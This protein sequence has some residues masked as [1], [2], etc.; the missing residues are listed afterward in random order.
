MADMRVISADSHMTEPGDLWVE[1]LDR[2]FRDNAP[3]VIKK[4][5]SPGSS[6]GA[7]Y[8]FVGPGFHPLTVA[9][10]FAAGRSGDELRE[11][12]RHGY[13]AARPSGWDPVERLKD[14]DLDGVSAE[15][16]YASLGIALLSMTDAD[17][18]QAC[19]RVYNDW[20][21]EFCSHA[22]NRLAGIG[23]FSLNSLP[24][25]SAI[26]HCAK[27]GLRGML[28]LASNTIDIP[29]SDERFDPLWRLASETGMPISLHKPLVSAM[30]TTPFMPSPADLQIHCIHVVEQCMTRL[31]YGGVFERFPRL[32]V[33]TIEA[34][35]GWVGEWLERFDYRYKY[36]GHTSRMKRPASEYFARNIWV[37]ADPEERMLPLMVQF[38]GDDKFFIGSDY[39]HAEGFVDP[40]R[41]A[42]ERLA[43]LPADSVN[44]VLSTTAREFYRIA[45][46]RWFSPHHGNPSP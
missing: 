7:P 33:A 24:N 5:A 34:A 16:L 22:P 42:R 4:E 46:R 2:K 9:G 17:L 43:S 28:V 3:R 8:V 41:K 6:F 21:A 20:L 12:M 26:E 44:K 18:Q 1:R 25:V 15:V 19:M 37:S 27:H 35:S 29:Y 45:K 11:H 38:A 14:Q 39:P 32:R 40:V 23:L 13:E 30:T 36:M 10:V 31:V